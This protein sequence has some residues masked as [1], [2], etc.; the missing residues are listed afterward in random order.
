MKLAPYTIL[1]TFNN[2]FLINVGTTQ[3][4]IDSEEFF[5][6]LVNLSHFLLTPR[7]EE[8]VLKHMKEENIEKKI[9][10]Y[11]K[12]KK[13]IIDDSFNLLDRNS[14]N[15]LFYNLIFNEYKDI[16]KNISNSKILLIG[17]GGIGN[18][19]GTML[20]GI[21]IKEIILIDG[22]SIEPHNLNRQF[23]FTNKDI[24]KNKALV[25]K[26]ELEKRND[27]IKIIAIDKMATEEIL[28][29]VSKD[30]DMIVFCADSRELV[31]VVNLVSVKNRIPM[32]N[33][34][35]INDISVIGP[36]YIPE[37][38]SCLV[39][40]DLNCFENKISFEE[41]F[42]SKIK[43]INL[44]YKSPSAFM[45][46]ALSSAMAGIEI[47]NC[48]TKRY[49]NL[50]SLNKRIGLINSNFKYLEIKVKKNLNC[51]VCGGSNE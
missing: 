31:K 37:I 46:N 21:G 19:L 41:S 29:E 45:N 5:S 49:D 34:G 7:N 3:E 30:V 10:E 47:L 23:L 33:I 4:V 22:D 24:G 1:D 8:D 39:C 15:H 14:R 51:P 16:Q 2:K 43:D 38:S 35:Y 40:S 26:E 27:D 12:E 25:L 28:Q 13:M 36:I 9:Y 44:R 6:Q 50:N 42:Y 17:C 18:F 32:L 11:M 20:T 48:L